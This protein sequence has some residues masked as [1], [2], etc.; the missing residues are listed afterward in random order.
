MDRP[1][2]ISSRYFHC[3]IKKPTV[4]LFESNIRTHGLAGEE[5]VEAEL[6]KESSEPTLPIRSHNHS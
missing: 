2:S 6:I 3:S 4:W 5:T 1:T